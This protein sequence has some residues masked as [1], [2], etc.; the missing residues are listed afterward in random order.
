MESRNNIR[1]FE[2]DHL[3][4]KQKKYKKREEEEKEKTYKNLRGENYV[5][6]HRIKFPELKDK[7]KANLY[8]HTE[9]SKSQGIDNFMKISTH[10]GQST[11]VSTEKEI[12]FK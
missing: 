9:W 2:N 8:Q 11:S 12:S 7:S 4:N 10:L 6:N 1:I 3:T 5:R